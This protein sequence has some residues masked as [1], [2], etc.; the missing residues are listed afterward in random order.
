MKPEEKSTA[1]QTVK[2]FQKMLKSRWQGKPL[3]SSQQLFLNASNIEEDEAKIYSG[4]ENL[5]ETMD[6][7]EYQMLR[8][9]TSPKALAWERAAFHL[10]TALE[11][12]LIQCNPV[13]VGLL[14]D[15]LESVAF[16]D[17]F[18]NDEELLPGRMEK[19]VKLAASTQGKKGVEA[20]NA[21]YA[22]AK[23][24]VISK[25]ENRTDI[26]QSKAAFALDCRAEIKK[27]FDLIV[28]PVTI[29][30]SWL[31]KGRPA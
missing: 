25:W 28:T 18:T 24:W 6:A 14:R 12:P 2:K 20:K 9:V 1:R 23:A 8:I 17:S 13:A 3:T 29:E 5:R 31:P 15:V 11:D 22:K 26:G 10:M 4:G 7:L 21:K 16:A 19:G 27:H 30:R